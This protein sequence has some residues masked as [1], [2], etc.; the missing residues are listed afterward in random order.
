MCGNVR[1]KEDNDIGVSAKINGCVGNALFDSG[2]QISLIDEKFVNQH[3]HQFIRTP[4]LPVRNMI[5]T[6]ATGD[7][8]SI[9]K[10]ALITICTQGVETEIPVLIV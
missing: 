5:V 3:K 9:G 1:I 4:I 6:T 8:Q 10:Q 7:S 2:A